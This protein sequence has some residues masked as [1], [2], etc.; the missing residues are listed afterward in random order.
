MLNELPK[1]SYSC[2]RTACDILAS[3]LY[4]NSILQNRA[5]YLEGKAKIKIEP[6]LGEDSWYVLWDTTIFKDFIYF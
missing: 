4:H 5:I 2:V 6:L 1:F 3:S